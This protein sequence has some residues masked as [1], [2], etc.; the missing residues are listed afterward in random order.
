[1]HQRSINAG[2]VFIKFF[3][4]GNDF[5]IGKDFWDYLGGAG[6]FED[7]IKIYE[8]RDKARVRKEI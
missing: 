6:A 8:E 7:L 5:L 1:M 2:H 4:K 3:D